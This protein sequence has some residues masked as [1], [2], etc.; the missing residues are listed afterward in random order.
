MQPVRFLLLLQVRVLVTGYFTP[1]VDD[2]EVDDA[3]AEAM[4]AREHYGAH[5]S[6]VWRKVCSILG[7]LQVGRRARVWLGGP[8]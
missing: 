4:Y 1:S 8:P 3:D 5:N 6:V 2:D 7:V